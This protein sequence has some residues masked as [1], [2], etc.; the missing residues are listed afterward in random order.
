V[1]AHSASCTRTLKHTRLCAH[2]QLHTHTARAHLVA[3]QAQAPDVRAGDEHRHDHD[4]V[5]RLQRLGGQVA[6][7]GGQAG[8]LP[9]AGGHAGACGRVRVRVR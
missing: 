7:H 9:P 1:Q 8:R 5:V 6:V 3:V 4:H 2:K